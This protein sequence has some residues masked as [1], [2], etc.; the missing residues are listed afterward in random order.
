MGLLPILS[1][2]HTVI[3]STMLKFYG[4]N[5]G[6]RLKNVTCKQALRLVRYFVGV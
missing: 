4:D 5:N 2:I 3:I 1:I 6:H